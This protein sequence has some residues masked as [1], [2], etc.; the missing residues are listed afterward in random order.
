MA[1]LEIYKLTGDIDFVKKHLKNLD[2]YLLWDYANRD[3]NGNGLLEW[4]IDNISV[5]RSGESGMD[6]SPRFDND[7]LLDAVDFNCFYVM[8][9]RSLSELYKA[10]GDESK[11]KFW[12]NLSESMAK[13]I[14]TE[15]WCEE[16]QF[17]LDRRTNG[18]FIVVDAI[19]SFLPLYAGIVS[20]NRAKIL[21]EKLFESSETYNTAVPFPSVPRNSAHFENDMWRGAVWLNYNYFIWAGLIRYGYTEYAEEVRKKTLDAV[22]YWYE[23]EGSIYEFY[24][25][26]NKISPLRMNR[27]GPQPEKTDIRKKLHAICDYNWS[28]SFVML[29]LLRQIIC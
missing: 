15:L 6:N 11:S 12:R 29:F 16:K 5:C 1:V 26:E 20:T 25:C 17:Y 2:R 14:N 21:V 13:K 18:E 10:V 7:Y 4:Q 8:D 27:K 28:A 22:N 3:K 9:S 23:K 24:D 19:S